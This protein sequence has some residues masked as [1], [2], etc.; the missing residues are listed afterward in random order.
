MFAKRSHHKRKL[1]MKFTIRD[2]VKIIFDLLSRISFRVSTVRISMIER[3][4]KI[5]IFEQFASKIT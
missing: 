2:I 3:I 4:M 5:I 1:K